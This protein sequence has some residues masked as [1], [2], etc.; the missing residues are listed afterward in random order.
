MNK[1]IKNLLNLIR[2]RQ[3][4]KNG[5]VFLGIILSGNI[6]SFHYYPRLFIGFILLCLTS[7][8]NYIINDIMDIEEDKQHPE[9]LKKKTFSIGR[10]IRSNRLWNF[11]SFY[12]NDNR[13]FTVFGS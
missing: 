12:W 8:L 6:F 10:N 11:N 7:S 1:K 5:L 9:K 4:Y 2:V 13:L 3:Y